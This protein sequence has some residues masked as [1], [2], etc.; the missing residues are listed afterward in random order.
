MPLSTNASLQLHSL[1]S[2]PGEAL[3]GIGKESMEKRTHSTVNCATTKL[4]GRTTCLVTRST[5]MTTGNPVFSHLKASLSLMLLLPG[6][7][8]EVMSGII[9]LKF[10]CYLLYIVYMFK[11]IVFNCNP[12]VYFQIF[13]VHYPYPSKSFYTTIHPS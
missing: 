3:S 12:Q 9:L 4:K 10:V 1:F 6:H 2:D 13:N 8:A 5:S 11:K 7:W